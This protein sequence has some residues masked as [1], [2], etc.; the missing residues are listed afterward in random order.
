[1]NV[2]SWMLTASYTLDG[3]KEPASMTPTKGWEPRPG[4][5]DG[6]AHGSRASFLSLSQPCSG[7]DAV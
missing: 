5:L 1:M 2:K 6:E 3:D 7:Q 4:L